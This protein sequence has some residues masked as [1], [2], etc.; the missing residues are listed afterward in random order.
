MSILLS[1]AIE[2]RLQKWI[3]FYPMCSCS[4][5]KSYKWSAKA[6]YNLFYTQ[7]LTNFVQ[8][9]KLDTSHGS[10]IHLLHY[11][12]LVWAQATCT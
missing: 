7:Q 5:Y 6:K 8:N 12:M 4:S 2:K 3:T 9:N 10:G 1:Q 11:V